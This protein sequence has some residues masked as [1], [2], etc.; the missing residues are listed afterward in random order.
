MVDRSMF[1]V[2]LPEGKSHETAIKSHK[3][4]IK[5]HEVNI[6]LQILKQLNLA[7]KLKHLVTTEAPHS[8]E[9][10]QRRPFFA[11]GKVPGRP[12]FSRAPRSRGMG[13]SPEKPWLPSGNLTKNCD[14]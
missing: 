10:T 12:K 14:L 13:V 5:S 3:T 7:K 6:R 2:C 8:A 4:A 9:T 1:F 11:R